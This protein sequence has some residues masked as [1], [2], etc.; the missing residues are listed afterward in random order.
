VA[1]G[2]TGFSK[3]ARVGDF[4][5]LKALDNS[6][7]LRISMP[8]PLQ[9]IQRFVVLMLE[10]RSFDHL[11]GYLK[12]VNP[13]VVGLTGNEYSNYPDPTTK[14]LPAVNVSSTAAFTM[15]FDPPHEFDDVQQQ[16]YG[17]V[18]ASPSLRINPAP[19]NGFLA[20]GN[21]A[22]DSNPATAHQGYRVMECF[23]AGQIPYLTALAQEFALFNFWYSGLPGPT[24]PNRFFVHAATSGGLSDSPDTPEIVLGY[25]FKANTIYHALSNAGKD[26]RIYHDG[27]PQTAGIDSLRFAYIDPFTRHFREMKYF[28]QDVK[29]GILPEYTFIEPNYDVGGNYVDGN[30]MHPLNDIRR[31]DLLVKTVYETLRNSNYWQDT[32]LIIT[33]DEHGGFFD[34]ISPPT[35]VPTGDDSSYA[36]PKNNFNFDL[37][38]VR[39]PGIVVSAF[40]QR[41]TVIGNDL[42]DPSTIFDHTSILATVEA[43][44]GLPPLTN[45]DRAANNLAVA[46]NLDLPR[47]DAPIVLQPN[48]PAP[49]S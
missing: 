4:C 10:N 32:M 30:S 15:P 27:M 47:N 9:N 21:A 49:I 48:P 7:L 1:S 14:L 16:L 13:Q 20:C 40:T 3:I 2:S 39:V 34:H 45:R 31:G 44:F 11:L 28:A 22:A 43:R 12:T 41:G 33:F 17:S 8:E 35:A 46:L 5:D 36:N 29:D 23:G 26:W 6:E 38:G 37:Y 42:Q 19:M 25:S 18:P 24:W